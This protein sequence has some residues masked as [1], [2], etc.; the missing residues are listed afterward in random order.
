MANQA[1]FTPNILLPPL[2]LLEEAQL[3][4]YAH[5]AGI[6]EKATLPEE[7][8]S[9]QLTILFDLKQ[10][11]GKRIGKHTAEASQQD[12]RRILNCFPQDP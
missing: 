7:L 2:L 4:H 8:L 5:F 10:E 3:L 9:E 12:I 1:K 11:C 6:C